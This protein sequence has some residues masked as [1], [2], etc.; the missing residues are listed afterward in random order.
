MSTT[1]AQILEGFGLKLE[2]SRATID[3]IVI[4]S[5]EKPT[6]NGLVRRRRL[7]A[8]DHDRVNGN[9]LFGL[10]SKTEF[11]LHLGIH[12]VEHIFRRGAAT[13]RIRLDLRSRWRIDFDRV[14]VSAGQSGL[15]DD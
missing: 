9:L 11:L 2:P 12:I 8:V 4:D 6:E 15:V 10:Q 3:V 5:I 14:F 13:A 7:D 1:D